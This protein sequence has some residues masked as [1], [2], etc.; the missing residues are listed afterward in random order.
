M[1]SNLERLIEE[2]GIASDRYGVA[3]ALRLL[4]WPLALRALHGIAPYAPWVPRINRPSLAFVLDLVRRAY[5][6]DPRRVVWTSVL[7]R[8]VVLGP[9]ADTFLS[10]NGCYGCGRSGAGSGQPGRSRCGGLP[11]GYMHHPSRRGWA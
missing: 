4:R 10:R 1:N 6:E 9:W 8:R 7:V 3:T 2:S 5:A 11:A